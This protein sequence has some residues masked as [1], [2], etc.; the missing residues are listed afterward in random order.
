MTD[1][2]YSDQGAGRPVLLLHGGGG[3]LTVSGFG[4]QL[5]GAG[6]RVITPSHPGFGGSPRPEN[7]TTIAQLAGLYAGLL[8]ELD[9]TDVTVVGNSIGGWIAAELALLR[10]PAVGRIALVDAVGIEV[11]DHPVADFF[12]L[13]FSQL[14]E[15]SYHDPAR[16]QIDP[17]ALT[18]EQQA[19]M[20]G[21]RAA[22][23]VYTAAGMSDP[24][25]RE[26]LAGVDVPVLVVWGDADRIADV[27]YGRAYAEAI[28]GSE[29]QLLS[30]TGHLPQLES[31][32]KL[33]ASI[34]S[35]VSSRGRVRGSR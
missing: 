15:L 24:T 25:L 23:A 11:A 20:A 34:E 2:T 29:F 31:P 22:L 5:A 30:E 6:F 26:R 33:R 28:P 3:P 7:V 18:P 21:N 32:D 10:F 1:L 16:F 14:A 35:F 9:L 12:S 27:G 13:T 17:T 19:M 8:A 4:A